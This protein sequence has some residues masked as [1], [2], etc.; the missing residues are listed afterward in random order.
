MLGN[1]LRKTRQRAAS[2]QLFGMPIHR[3]VG[4][5]SSYLG[6]RQSQ[7]I[8]VWYPSDTRGSLIC[9]AFHGTK[10]LWKF[11]VGRFPEPIALNWGT[12]GSTGHRGMAKTWYVLEE[13]ISTP[14]SQW[15]RV[16]LRHLAA[17]HLSVQIFKSE[18]LESKFDHVLQNKNMKQQNSWI[19]VGSPHLYSG[20]F[21][22]VHFSESFPCSPQLWLGVP[23]MESSRDEVWISVKMWPLQWWHLE[24]DGMFG[25]QRFWRKASRKSRVGHALKPIF[26]ASDLK[27]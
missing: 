3:R 1:C 14:R 18:V 20:F 21:L 10:L 4:S 8:Y 17:L 22:C 5:W 2:W 7:L 23:S 26:V 9:L 11:A 25:A 12:Q 13:V 24:F 16:F 6:Q 15:Y 27:S 19:D